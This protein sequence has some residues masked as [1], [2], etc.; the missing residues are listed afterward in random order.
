MLDI[1]LSA[2]IMASRDADLSGESR[3]ETEVT[4]DIRRRGKHRN[5]SWHSVRRPSFEPG[6]ERDGMAPKKTC[7]GIALGGTCRGKR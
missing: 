7:R 4:G 6:H 5:P 2:A 1:G 3:Y